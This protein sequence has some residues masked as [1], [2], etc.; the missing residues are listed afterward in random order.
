MDEIL[1]LSL[2]QYVKKRFAQ[3][4]KEKVNAERA[5]TIAVGEY[6]NAALQK[7]KKEASAKR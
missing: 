2:A 5:Y 4:L 1:K 3:L 7:A 6:V